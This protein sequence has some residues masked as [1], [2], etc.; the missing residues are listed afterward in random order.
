[1]PTQLLHTGDR[2]H[3][4]AVV[5]SPLLDRLLEP[6]VQSPQEKARVLQERVGAGLLPHRRTTIHTRHGTVKRPSITMICSNQLGPHRGS[7]WFVVAWADCC[8][9]RDRV[10]SLLFLRRAPVCSAAVRWRRRGGGAAVA[11]KK[12]PSSE[13]IDE[14]FEA[15]ATGGYIPALWS[16]HCC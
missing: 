3:L 15:D 12:S 16:S 6:R 2:A 11:Q 9:Y 13:D 10:F 1:V 4:R 7:P 5:G 8:A 14:I